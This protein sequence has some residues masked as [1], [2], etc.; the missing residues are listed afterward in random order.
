MKRRY[1]LFIA[2]LGLATLAIMAQ[3]TPPQLF[4]E[5]LLNGLTYRNMG[6][7]RA[8]AWAVGMAIPETPAK[9]HR[10]TIYA[11][12]RSGGVWKSSNGGVTFEPVLDSQNIYS[13]G[14]I[15]V[16]P[17]N[18]NV[19]WVGTGDNSATRSAYWGDGV[20]KSTDAG[21]TWQNMGLKESHHIA[22]IVI[23]PTRPDTVYVAALGHLATPNDERG[24]FKTTDGGK[25]WK[26][27]HFVNSRTGAVDLVRDPR[28]PEVLYVATYEHERLAWVI[29][30]GGPGTGIYKTTDGGANW[31]ELTNGLPKGPMGRIGMDICRTKPD[32][33]YAVYDN[34]NLRPN[35]RS[36]TDT[37]NGQVYRTDDAGASW[38]K[39]TPDEVDPSGK[40]A[41][42]FNQL[43]VDPNNPDRIYITGS[44]FNAS[45]DGGKTWGGRGGVRVFGRAFGDFRSIWIDPEDSDRMIAT[46]DGGV[47]QS[48]DGGRTCEHYQTI[49]GGEVYAL[50]VDMDIPYNIY[51][52]LQDHESWKGPSNGW[53][54]S[55]GIDDW[56]TVGTG[57]G[58][59]NQVDPTDSRWV[60]NTQE[61]GGL[62]R[63]DQKTHVRT[64]I[65]PTRPQPDPK[66]QGA[67]AKP[68]LPPLRINWIA[69]F[70][71][72][73]HDPKTIYA[74]AQV[75]FKSTDRGDHWQEIS[76]DLT[77]NDPN[78]IDQG[79]SGSNIVYCDISTLSESPLTRGLLWIGTDDGKTWV[80]RND[81]TNWTEVTKN[82]AAAGGPEDV[83]VSRVYA[84]RFAAGTAYVAKTGRRQD[85]F[86]PYLFKTTDF[87][88]TWKNISA[89]LP[90]WPVNSILEDLQ[91]PSVLFAGTDIGIYVS[92]NGGA[93]WV[94]LKSNMAPAPVTDMVIHPREQD[95]VA[96]TYGRGVWI[97]DVAP[98][99]EMTEEN[100][101]KAAHL[102]AVKPKPIR[103]DGATGNYRLLG[104]AFPSTPNEPNGLLIY[105][106]LK[107]DAAQP[108]SITIADQTGKVVRTLTGPQRAGINRVSS[109]GGGGGG[110]GGRGGQ[111][112]AAM[113]P[114][115]YVVTL[116][117]GETKLTQKARVT[118]TPEFR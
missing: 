6:P 75:V 40:A 23:H 61:F 107:Q 27:V 68:Q 13:M 103:R 14:A 110:G 26:K 77:N 72:S 64:R 50:G 84:S 41:Y 76:P 53:A 96:G 95:L 57:D 92:I 83:W 28:N 38:R 34:H 32:V 115:D 116:T 20:Y 70:L 15:A 114:G 59:Y 66:L 106:H 39:V 48:F 69:P 63:Y 99:R 43:A 54:G 100:L 1:L 5:T 65:A 87:G 25:S 21:K 46:S 8:G 55:I 12:L 109:E 111:G 19:V 24:V 90:Q 17:S 45:S 118:P 7:Y 51:A 81:G 52:G 93:R 82:I 4:N 97:V 31:T 88:A 33:L 94:A 102:F 44:S 18:E 101:A 79:K 36:K 86:K 78:K 47:F 71:L 49:R 85:I 56:V 10:T 74:G 62:G 35:P 67:Q 60:Y 91:N 11:A 80:T 117:V 89:N 58:M 30:D 37:I 29:N 105:Y 108:V 16:A 22:R 42:S 73:P 2:S 3:Q 104:D 112:A 9:A 98:I 113:P